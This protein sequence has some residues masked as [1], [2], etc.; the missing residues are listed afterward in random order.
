MLIGGSNS[1]A[2]CFSVEAAI[3]NT[4]VVA[5]GTKTHESASESGIKLHYVTGS[6][7]CDLYVQLGSYCSVAILHFIRSVALTAEEVGSL[8]SG[9][10]E[11]SIS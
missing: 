2:K 11:V 7:G 9:A 3:S 8:P 6:N 5:Y 1:G 4:G 10:V